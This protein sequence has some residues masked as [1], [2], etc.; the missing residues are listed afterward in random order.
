[1]ISNVQGASAHSIS[2]Y[3][4]TSSSQNQVVKEQS[5]LSVQQEEITISAEAHQKFALEQEHSFPHLSKEETERVNKIN[6]EID[7]ILGTEEVKFSKVDQKSADKLYQQIDSIFA[8][9]KVTKEEEKQLEKIDNKLS[10]IYQ[11]YEKPLTAEQEKKLDGLFSELDSILGVD[12][13]DLFGDLYQG[14]GLSK[15]DQEKADKLNA[16][17]DKV[18]GMDKPFSKE[19]QKAADKLFEQMDKIFADEKVTDGEEKQLTKL[20]EQLDAILKKY[21]KPLT[22]ADEKKLDD[23]FGQLDDLYGL[24]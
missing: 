6:A 17:I 3:S 10:D 16:E 15:A 11:K 9:D 18:L 8:D 12:D 14:L 21:E 20:D 2:A 4:S 7:K 22:E 23:L 24:S 5:L 13:D 19:D 1:M